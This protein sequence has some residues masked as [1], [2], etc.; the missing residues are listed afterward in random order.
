[1]AFYILRYWGKNILNI[2]TQFYN[3]NVCLK[4]FTLEDFYISHDGK[5]IIMKNLFTYSF[6]NINGSIY[7]GPD[8]NKILLLLDQIPFSDFEKKGLKI[9]YFFVRTSSR[10]RTIF[11]RFS[12]LYMPMP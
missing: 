9:S 5:R 11:C 12:A 6:Y 3:M 4:Y 7:N 1:M 2:L 8:L 10:K